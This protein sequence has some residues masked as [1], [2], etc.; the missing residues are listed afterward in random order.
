MTEHTII[1]ATGYEFVPTH[2]FVPSW[3]EDELVKVPWSIAQHYPDDVWWE[4]I[5]QDLE[6]GAGE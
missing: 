3:Y 1:D 6:E 4:E 5:E 2:V